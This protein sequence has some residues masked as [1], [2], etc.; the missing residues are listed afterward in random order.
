MAVRKDREGE[1]QMT[2]LWERQPLE[3]RQAFAA[4]CLYRDLGP[5]RSL[6]ASYRHYKGKEQATAPGTWRQWCSHFAWPRRATAY[7]DHLDGIR[8]AA[9]EK[10]IAKVEAQRVR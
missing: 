7:D 10:T 2:D 3:S 9:A 8:R 6:D 4:F 5:T 1:T